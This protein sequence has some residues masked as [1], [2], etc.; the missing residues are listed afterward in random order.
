MEKTISDLY[1]TSGTVAGVARAMGYSDN[2][3]KRELITCGLLETE[4]SKLY[5]QGM[6]VGEIVAKAGKPRHIVL[7]NLPYLD[8][9]KKELKPVA[10]DRTAD[11]VCILYGTGDS[12]KTIA[13]R[14]E[15]SEQKVRRILIADGKIVTDESR[16]YAQGY[17]VE[18]IC[19]RTGK[20]RNAV[21]G[22]LPYTKGLYD[23]E[24]PTRNAENIR[25]HR[26]VNRLE[27]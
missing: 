20:K 21:L 12:I 25:K 2:K 8:G 11:Y 16:M 1:K 24:K 14:L 22:R 13:K 4:E 17:T 15:I 19:K 6:T 23:A 5:A 10:G 27:N 9:G 18:E 26:K 7:N 3:A